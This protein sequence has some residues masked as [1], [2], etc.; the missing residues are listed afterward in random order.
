MM[1]YT[2]IYDY[3]T[4]YYSRDDRMHRARLYLYARVGSLP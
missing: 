2:A 4:T 1:Y 3:Y